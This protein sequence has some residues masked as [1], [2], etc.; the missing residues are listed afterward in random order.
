[1][2]PTTCLCGC[3]AAVAPGRFFIASHDRRAEAQ[4]IREQYGTIA[5]F[6]LAHR[7]GT[8]SWENHRAGLPAVQRSRRLSLS[9]SGR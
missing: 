1:M 6:V 9:G 8:R 3:G 5:D 4:I 7:D 2:P